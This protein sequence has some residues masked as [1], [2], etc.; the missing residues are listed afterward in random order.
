MNYILMH[1]NVPVAAL[2]IADDGQIMAV[3][4]IYHKEH[5]PIGVDL[6]QVISLANWWSGRSIPAS[7]KGLSQLLVD[8]NLPS[9]HF[10][11]VKSFGLSLSD[12]YWIKPQNTDLCWEKINFFEHEFSRD[13]GEAFFNPN[14]ENENLDFISP[15]NTSDGWLKKKWI[16]KDNQ[17]LLVKAGSGPYYQEPFNEVIASL[18]GEKLGMN[19]VHYELYLDEQQGYCCSCPNFVDAN[20]ELIPAYAIMKDEASKKIKSLYDRLVHATRKY[21]I[22]GVEK[23]IDDIIVLDYLVAGTDR[24]FGNF[25]F[26]RNSETLEFIGPAPIFDSGTSLWNDC[27]DKKIGCAVKAMPFSGS[28]EEQLKLVKGWNRYD[29]CA[30]EESIKDIKALLIFNDNMTGERIK[31]I[32]E[33]IEERVKVL[34]IR[35][36]MAL[37]DGTFDIE[38]ELM[39][40]SYNL[41]PVYVY[42]RDKLIGKTKYNP[43]LDKLI[44]KILLNFGYAREKVV[45][46]LMFSPNIKSK[47]MA[48]IC[49]E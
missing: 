38:K 11:S 3:A 33:A 43:E 47:K 39:C 9:A 26:L 7:R 45:E 24:H 40:I 21:S 18:I 28:Q 6:K 8:Y 36:K 46:I 15:D 35:Q 22:P 12:Q 4:E 1:K 42:Y 34:K 41:E 25:G 14:F 20:T 5:A 27:V 31:G 44:A 13:I 48:E 2:E 17:R 37:N 49:L 32:A 16:I 19:I 23:L 10:L 30:L 29:F